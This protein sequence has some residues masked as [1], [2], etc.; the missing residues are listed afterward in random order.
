[1]AVPPAS[2]SRSRRKQQLAVAET[3]RYVGPVLHGV[4]EPGERILA[5]AHAII[6]WA[7]RDACVAVGLSCWALLVGPIATRSDLS[8]LGILLLGAL[9][10]LLLTPL[11]L[12]DST[13]RRVFIAVTDRQLICVRYR[14]MSP[15]RV[16]FH[17]PIGSFQI[18]R[19]VSRK[20]YRSLTYV[21]P[22]VP[23][24]GLRVSASGKWRQDMDEVTAA[25][26]AAGVLVEGFVPAALAQLGSSW[27]GG[28]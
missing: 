10:P 8:P 3:K 21:G 20:K 13:R 12:F 15:S 27:A 25:L 11:F 16:R 5:G 7:W 22:G 19:V 1:M 26:Q 14:E 4:M 18:R 24:S 23:G 6:G 17:V 28:R 9:A 2:D